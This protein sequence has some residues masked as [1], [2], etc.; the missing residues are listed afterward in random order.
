[1]NG[2]PYLFGLRNCC[3]Q[4]AECTGCGYRA[5]QAYLKR[6]NDD[7]N[8]GW[9][10]LY[11][12]EDI[13][14]IR[15]QTVVDEDGPPAIMM[16][17]LNIHRGKYGIMDELFRKAGAVDVY[18]EVN[19]TGEGGETID[20]YANGLAQY[21]HKQQGFPWP[22]VDPDLVDRIDYVYVKPSGAG[23]RLVPTK[24]RVDRGWKYGADNMDLSD[25]YPLFVKFRLETG[26]KV[27]IKG[28]FDCDGFVDLADLAILC[29]AWLSGPG[30]G[31]WDRA[32]DISAPGDDFIDMKD[33]EEFARQWRIM[34][35]HNVTRNK[36]YA[37]IQAAINDANDGEEI[38]V[39][40]G[41]YY[42]GI[43][44]DGKAIR[45]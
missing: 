14:I 40:P 23:L 20:I 28:D 42:G 9:E 34:A 19:G 41:T 33:F 37:S 16:G 18:I 22:P 32:C 6:I 7:P 29:S 3:A 8:T 35:I 25:H 43:N 11:Q 45:L 10:N 15:D 26:C 27:H 1:M 5:G 30:S 31:V 36:W 39:A 4:E 38:E 2:H 44:F 13:R 24:A 12:L 17:D 21:F